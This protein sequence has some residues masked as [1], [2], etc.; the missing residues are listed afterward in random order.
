MSTKRLIA[1]LIRAGED[2]ESTLAMERSQL[3]DA[4]AE[5]V[6]LGRDRPPMPM[7]A[8]RVITRTTTEGELGLQR[9]VFEFEMRKFEEEREERRRR[10][11]LERQRFEM[12]CKVREE[13]REERR[14]R[15]D[16][17]RRAKE[18]ERQ[19]R[20]K[21]I[22]LKEEELARQIKRDK[23]IGD[24]KQS[25]ASRTKFFGEAMKNVFWKFPQDPAEIPGYF[26]HVENLFDLYEVDEDVK[27]ELLQAHLS[28]RAKA[29]TVRLT[30]D[31]LDD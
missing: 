10:S 25:L 24:K 11:E 29:L 27:S 30:R 6:V 17:E 1:S 2:E 3:L 18:E 23:E 15:A 13:E 20:E 4:W 28:D 31:C 9:R 26:D 5:L 21:E 7:E 14:M 22:Q 8:E 19:L 16:E 12:E